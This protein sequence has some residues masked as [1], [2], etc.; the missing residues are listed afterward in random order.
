M[1]LFGKKSL[2]QHFLNSPSALQ[3]IIDAAKI[4]NGEK[5]L[6]IGPGT[7]ILTNPLIASGARVIAVEKD[8][9]AYDLISDTF[10]ESIS[11]GKLKLFSDDI[12]LW[13]RTA[14]DLKDGQYSIV[15]N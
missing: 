6:E 7:G 2:G 9:R 3:K 13:N 5:V 15:A 12:L 1:K 8:Q 10:K 11:E 14:A 4:Q